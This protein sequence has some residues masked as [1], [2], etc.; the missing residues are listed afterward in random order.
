MRADIPGARMR[1]KME[2]IVIRDPSYL[3]EWLVAAGVVAAILMLWGVV[4]LLEGG[5]R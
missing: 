5:L 1:V 2:G 3:R 4:G